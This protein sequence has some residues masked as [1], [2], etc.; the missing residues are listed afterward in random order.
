MTPDPKKPPVLLK[1]K[2]KQD[3]RR[4]CCEKALSR[5][6]VC[7]KYVP[8][9][10]YTGDPLFANGHIHHKKTRGAG[11]DDSLENC[12]WVCI[13]CHDRIHRGLINIEGK[14]GNSK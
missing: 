4:E 6:T 11:G 3:L 14:N 9:S 1:G 5:C 12:I 13:G 10:S 8:L 7:G 2:A